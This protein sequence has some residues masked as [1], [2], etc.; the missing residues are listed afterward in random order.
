MT[1]F[2]LVVNGRT[3]SISDSYGVNIASKQRWCI[4][5]ISQEL[6]INSYIRPHCSVLEAK[7]VHFDA[8]ESQIGGVGLWCSGVV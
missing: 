3:T 8:E 7:L 6:G 1:K 4:C 2:L 5:R